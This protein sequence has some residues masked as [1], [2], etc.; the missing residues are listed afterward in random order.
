M[1][2]ENID[3]SI[4]QNDATTMQ[5]ERKLTSK[6]NTLGQ[7][8]SQGLAL[9]EKRIGYFSCFKIYIIEVATPAQLA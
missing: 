4:E 7:A 2:Q 8:Y 1:I 3:V 6:K 5:K 9:L